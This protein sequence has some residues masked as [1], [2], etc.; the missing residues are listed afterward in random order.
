MTVQRCI[1]M[2]PGS[3][4]VGL[5]EQS[6]YKADSLNGTEFVSNCFFFIFFL[7]TF[8]LTSHIFSV[9]YPYFLLVFDILLFLFCKTRYIKIEGKFYDK[10]CGSHG[11]NTVTLTVPE[12][13]C[14]STEYGYPLA[15]LP[16]GWI[17]GYE[18]DSSGNRYVV[19]QPT[20]GLQNDFQPYFS[21]PVEGSRVS[22][23]SKQAAGRPAIPD[24]SL[25]EPSNN[26]QPPSGKGEGSHQDI[27]GSQHGTTPEHGTR[28]TNSQPEAPEGNQHGPD[29]SH[30]SGS[31]TQTTPAPQPDVAGSQHGTAL[32][33][34]HP[35]AANSN[36]QGPD[37]LSGSGG[38]IFTTP[39]PQPTIPMNPSGSYQG[40]GNR[41][42]SEASN[43]SGRGEPNNSREGSENSTNSEKKTVTISTSKP[44]MEVRPS[45]SN[46]QPEVAS[47]LET[48]TGGI[49]KEMNG[50][51]STQTLSASGS[52]ESGKS[53]L[54]VSEANGNRAQ[55]P[56]S[57]ISYVFKEQLIVQLAPFRPMQR[58]FIFIYFFP[59]TSSNSSEDRL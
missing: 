25:T 36:Q 33:P 43:G 38:Q 11:E 52:E 2:S 51:E 29:N 58:W 22:L 28:P 14:Q 7:F 10:A 9:H 13:A 48:K 8:F 44:D 47:T 59:H 50:P 15:Q 20:S 4:Y 34:S 1:D 45:G 41:A 30:G 54:I 24:G 53:P 56:R 57:W 16:P 37:N 31:E 17:G 23:P 32:N 18:T 40:P 39:A 27:P 21:I 12:A 19:A 3:K 35:A 49:S 5:Y 26:N 55:R 6:C 46:N 42:G